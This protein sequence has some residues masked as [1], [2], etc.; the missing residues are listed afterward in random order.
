[1]PINYIV[2]W[3]Q[4]IIS[5]QSEFARSSHFGIMSI[6]NLHLQGLFQNV[7]LFPLPPSI[8]CYCSMELL[9]L[10][11]CFHAKCGISLHR[12]LYVMENSVVS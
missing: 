5:S 12:K 1:V 7:L 4:V 9:A 8:A 2:G 6:K 10:Y 3:L 11:K